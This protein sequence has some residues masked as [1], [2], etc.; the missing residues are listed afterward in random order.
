MMPMKLLNNKPPFLQPKISVLEGN[1]SLICVKQSPSKFIDNPSARESSAHPSEREDGD[2]DGVQEH[3][4][5]VG[6]VLAV[7]ALAVRVPDE[8]LNHLKR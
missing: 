1:I 2:G 3:G 8:L 6:H 7:V 5:V 4:G